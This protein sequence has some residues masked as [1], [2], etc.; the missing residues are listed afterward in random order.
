MAF[1]R[2]QRIGTLVVAA[3]VVVAGAIALSVV[4]LGD[5]AVL[6]EKDAGADRSASSPTTTAEK[7]PATEPQIDIAQKRSDDPAALAQLDYVLAHWSDYN[8]GAYGVIDDNDCVNFASQSLIQRGWAMDE[9]WWSEGAGDEFDFTDAWVSSTA[10]RDYLEE[11]GRATALAD[12]QRAEVKLGDI[13]QFDWD[14]SG[15]R[16]HTAVVTGISGSGD[17]IQIFYGGHT[18][19]TDYRSVDWAITENHRG[20]SVFYWSV[21]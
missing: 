14:N 7:E 8:L 15:D 16:D 10:F 9:D 4:L 11:S 21:P 17:D 6:G 19:D 1:T 20:A 12:T 18:D 5:G 13:V 2:G 3:G